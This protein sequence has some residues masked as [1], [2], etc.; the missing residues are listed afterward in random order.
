MGDIPEKTFKGSLSLYTKELTTIINNCLK[1]ILFL[2][3]LKL[4]DVS[5]VFKKDDGL[6]KENYRSVSILPYMSNFLGR[7]FYKQIDRFIA[8]KFLPFLSG[9]RKNHNSQYS[10]LKMIE[11]WRKILIKEMKLLSS[12]WIFQKLLTQ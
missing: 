3:E 7:A 6:N 2:N 4:A 9:F 5:P 10:L 12:L 11:V 1:D 8:S